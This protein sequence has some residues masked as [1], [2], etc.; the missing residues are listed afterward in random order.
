MGTN[1]VVAVVV[2]VISAV[3]QLVRARCLRDVQ[4]F[5]FYYY[6]KFLIKTFRC[7]TGI[8]FGCVI[9]WLYFYGQSRIRLRNFKNY[10]E[11][12]FAVAPLGKK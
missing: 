3:A 9:R 4:L 10:I 7:I 6:R 1:K 11:R 12:N 2:V 5:N 8:F